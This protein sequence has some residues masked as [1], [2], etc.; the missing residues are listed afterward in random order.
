MNGAVPAL[1]AGLLLGAGIFALTRVRGTGVKGEIFWLVC[2]LTFTVAGGFAVARLFAA[3]IQPVYATVMAFALTVGLTAALIGTA[4]IL[5]R[6]LEDRWNTVALAIPAVVYI[7][8]VLT[9]QFVF[10]AYVQ[11]IVVIGL[12]GLAAW[13]F[14]TH[15]RSAMWIIAACVAFALL[16]PM[17]LR[18]APISAMDAGHL[19]SALGVLALAQAA[20]AQ[21]RR[22]DNG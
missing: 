22:A 19:A 3:G 11:I 21:V 2:F 9:N 20:L 16:T 8:A 18:V 10:T 17:I 4:S 1:F 14:E 12:T 13:K 15:P 5:V 6:P 7:F